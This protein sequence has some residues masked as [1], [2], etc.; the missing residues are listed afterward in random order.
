MQPANPDS[1]SENSPSPP[2]FFEKTAAGVIHW[3]LAILAVA[4]VL[5]FLA[6]PIAARLSFDES[7]ESL[8]ADDDPHFAAFARSKSHFGGD[9]FAIVAWEETN[10]FSEDSTSVSPDSRGRI[11]ALSKKLSAIP[12]VESG[13]AQHAV[14]ALAF[15]YK[16]DQ[17]TKLI[18]GV[19]IGADHKTTAVVVRLLPESSAPVSRAETVARIRQLA[20]TH[21]P[22]AYVVGEPV[23]IHDMF[24]YVEEDGHEL[25]QF[26]LVLLACV[27]FTLFRTMRWVVLPI[28]VVVFT[29]RWTEAILVLAGAQLSMVSSMMNSLVT[30]VGVATSTHLAMRFR[31]YARTMERRPALVRAVAELVPPIFWTC[32]TTAV[33]FASLLSSSI[34]PVRSFGLMMALATL[35][36]FIVVVLIAPGGMARWFHRTDGL[37]R[38]STRVN[39]WL[40]MIAGDPIP[41]PAERHLVSV[42]QGVSQFVERRPGLVTATALSIVLLAT[43][44]MTRLRVETDFSRNFREESELVQSLNF[45]ETRLGGAGTWEVNFPAPTPLTEEFLATVRDLAAELRASLLAPSQER[46][47]ATGRLTKVVSLTDGLDLV[48]KE[49]GVGFLSKSLSLDERLGLLSNMQGEVVSGLYDPKNGRMRIALRGL[50][51]QK[52]EAKLK[53]IAEVD[54]IAREV[55]Q[56]SPRQPDVEQAAIHDSQPQPT[57][58]AAFSSQSVETTGMFVL[59]TFL[60]ESLL[61][62]QLISFG[63]AAVGIGAMMAIAFRSLTIGLIALVPN[64]FPIVLVL[65]TMGWVGVPINIASAMI[66]SVSMGLTVDNSVHYLSAYHRVRRSGA[67]VHEAIA[68]TQ[69]QVGR[70]LVFANVAL[71]AGLSVL[72]M[73]QFIPLVYFGILVS[74]AMLGG[75]AGNLFLLPLMLGRVDNDRPSQTTTVQAPSTTN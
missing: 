67:S 60:I 2:N 32:A 10:L 72:T 40:H 69:T 11:E 44:G 36:I 43:I 16:R 70:S 18:E 73:S 5:T 49:I 39:S 68:R 52:S 12:G 33:G 51:R 17:V 28:V 47:A 9:E 74:V 30:I 15:P 66:A 37:R 62:D 58:E 4:V 75:L 14:G 46:G 57:T 38:D 55:L 41:A 7:I 65:G 34:T 22:A 64:V 13:S 23:Q 20:R 19:L 56:F 25:F 3:R 1:N 8:Y 59:L 31:E 42:L 27:L 26:S 35:L 21:Q 63:I 53:L 29:I 61:R 24:R 45:V 6:W 48:P 50:E 54:E 71:I